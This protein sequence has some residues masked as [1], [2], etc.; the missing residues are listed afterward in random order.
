[1]HPLCP[2]GLAIQ[3]IFNYIELLFKETTHMT[4]YYNC[5]VILY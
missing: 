2:D 1:M 5:S 4:Q 3:L